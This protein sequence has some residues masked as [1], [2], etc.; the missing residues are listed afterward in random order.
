MASK[1]SKTL[2][3]SVSDTFRPTVE[4]YFGTYSTVKKVRVQNT[5]IAVLYR[6]LQLAVLAYIAIYIV[7]IK[8]GY[9]DVQIP[10]GAS[11]I[12][13]K[14]V[15]RVTANR[16]NFV[17]NDIE[18][19][20][21]DAAEYLVPPLENN[22]FF[23]ATRKIVTYNQTLGTC[24][25]GGLIEIQQQWK[26]NFDSLKVEKKCFP[27][28]TFNLLQ[29]GS[30]ELS[31]GINYRFAEKYSVN[32]KKYRTLT[33]IYGFRFIVAINGKGRQFDIVNLFVA[34]GSGLGYMIIGEIICGFV[35]AR[36]HKYS[37]EYR[38]VKST[39][40]KLRHVRDPPSPTAHPAL[41]NLVV[42]DIRQS[43]GTV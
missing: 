25:S 36:F 17:S 42:K 1:K 7:Y 13:V 27:T 41:S 5:S 11:V 38:Q 12:K 24:P 16:S 34:I 32:G 37:T 19:D 35:F 20:L 15:A 8:K 18:E 4:Y 30:D 23:V 6:F 28:F 26:C 9:Q 33:K 14:G 40:L 2:W 3:S 21:W 39:G 29:S 22:A 43:Q 10:S 31:P